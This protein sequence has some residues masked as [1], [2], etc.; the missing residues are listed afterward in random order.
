MK[1]QP[2]RRKSPAAASAARR[3]YRRWSRDEVVREIR[4]ISARGGQL[5]SGHVARTFPALAYAARK[6]VGSWEA[7]IEAA[8]LDYSAIRRK[9]FWNRRRIVERI[10]ELNREGK[11][12][13]VSLAE[14]EYRGL[15]GAATM[16]FGSWQKAIRAA[17]LDY[18]KI[19]RQ[20]DWSRSEVVREI[21]RMRREKVELG[22][23]IPV[24]KKYRNL[25]AAAIRY[26]GSWAEAMRAAGLE[27]LL[28]GRS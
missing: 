10:K 17:G 2:T 28:G 26:F 7:A 15:V 4:S 9:N 8:G 19:K 24:R 6:Y 16:Y 14:R 18:S 21:R 12:L 20:K 25:H 13:H 1:D 23:T 3:R 27:R 22:T 5:N 11:P